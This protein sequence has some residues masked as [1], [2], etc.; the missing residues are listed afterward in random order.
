[1]VGMNLTSNGDGIT[2]NAATVLNIYPCS[3]SASLPSSAA[4]N[5]IAVITTNEITNW[6][7]SAEEPVSPSAGAI[8]II[9]REGAY[10]WANIGTTTAPINIYP[11][12]VYQYISGAWVYKDSYIWQNN[13]WMRIIY[14]LYN[15]GEEY[16]AITGGLKV[17]NASGGRCAINTDNLYLGYSGS[18][19]RYG[20]VY[21]IGLID[22]TPFTRLYAKLAVTTAANFYVGFDT[23]NSVTGTGNWVGNQINQTAVTTE[24]V[25]SC[26]ISDLTGEYYL[27]CNASVS[28]GNIYEIWLE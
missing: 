14:Y 23:Q 7:I 1:M 25:L 20:H 13:Q 19:A 5:D 6:C 16:A 21:S 4:T 26:D 28:N 17:A 10:A 8:W 22:V 18:G 27:N 12:C 9:T 11:A 15:R 2:V 3:S 24:K